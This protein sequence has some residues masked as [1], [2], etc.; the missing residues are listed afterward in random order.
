MTP[1]QN[2]IFASFISEATAYRDTVDDHESLSVGRLVRQLAI[3]IVR[4]YAS[5]LL[6]PDVT[7][8]TSD[9]PLEVITDAF[10]HEQESGLTQALEEKFGSYNTYREIFDPYDDPR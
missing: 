1:E 9:N 10:T 6:L 8:Q 3:S 4:L 2:E 5:A 7:S